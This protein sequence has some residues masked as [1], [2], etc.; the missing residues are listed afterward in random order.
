MS[1][2]SSAVRFGGAWLGSSTSENVCHCLFQ[3]KYALCQDKRV[4]A[5]TFVGTN[6]SEHKRVWAQ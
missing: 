5:Q 1:W 3:L 4:L 6:V 2:A